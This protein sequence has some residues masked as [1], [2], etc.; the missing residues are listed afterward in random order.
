MQTNMAAAMEAS[1]REL[2]FANGNAVICVTGSLHA[3][4][5]ARHFGKPFEQ[6]QA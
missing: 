4:S 1:M 6:E 2:A 3:V 5:A